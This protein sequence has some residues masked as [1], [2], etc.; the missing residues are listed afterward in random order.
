MLCFSIL[1]DF[2]YPYVEYHSLLGYLRDHNRYLKKLG[3][4]LES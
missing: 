3:A 4:N 2:D 1:R